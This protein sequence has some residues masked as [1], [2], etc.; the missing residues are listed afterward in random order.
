MG[1][2]VNDS[3]TMQIP[4]LAAVSD[5]VLRDAAFLLTSLGGDGAD[6][7]LIASIFCRAG[8]VH[9]SFTATPPATRDL[10]E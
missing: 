4:G 6:R 8:H 10:R 9:R 5:K 7:G 1:E 2:V 3:Q